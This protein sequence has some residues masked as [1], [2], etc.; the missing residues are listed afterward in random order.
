MSGED[1]QPSN[2]SRL[3]SIPGIVALAVLGALIVGVARLFGTDVV[4]REVLMEVIA[5]FGSALVIISVFGLLFKSGIER[6]IR[7]APGGDLYAQST[8]SLREMLENRDDQESNLSGLEE[9]LSRIERNLA[10]LS[11]E[12]LPEL[13][14]E[15]QELRRSLSDAEDG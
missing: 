1:L 2:L 4:L 15:I 6:L 9:R 7:R 10:S 12:R 8:E 13:K 11:G 14:E 3:I 5:S